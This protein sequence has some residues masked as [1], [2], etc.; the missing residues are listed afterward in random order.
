MAIQGIGNEQAGG[1]TLACIDIEELILLE[2]ERCLSWQSKD[3]Q[4]FDKAYFWLDQ[5]LTKLFTTYK[6]EHRVLTHYR[7]FIAHYLNLLHSC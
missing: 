6:G 4:E 2:H 3:I 7:C 1:M 5:F